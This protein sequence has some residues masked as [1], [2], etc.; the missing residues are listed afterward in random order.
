MAKVTVFDVADFFLSKSVNNTDFAITHL[1]LQKLV[2]YAQAWYVT[3]FPDHSPLFGEEIEAWVHGPVCRELYHEYSTYGF[4]EILAS[5]EF[6]DDYFNQDQLDVLNAVWQIYGRFDGKTLESLTHTE[7]PWIEARSG[8]SES[9][10]SSNIIDI[11]AMRE[12]YSKLN[13]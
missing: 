9:E 5:E 10:Y 6:V 4:R 7:S 3:A 2:Y 8:L 13:K 11:K 1:K 12:Y